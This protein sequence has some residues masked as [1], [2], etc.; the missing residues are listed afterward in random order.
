MPMRFVWA[1]RGS[2]PAGWFEALAERL[3]E[4]DVVAVDAGHLVLMER[5][6]LVVEAALR[7]SPAPAARAAS[8]PTSPR[9]ATR[10]W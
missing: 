7:F 4:A 2:F 1:R 5:P 3:P 10:R 6:E 8:T 9:A